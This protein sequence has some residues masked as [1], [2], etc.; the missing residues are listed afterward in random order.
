MKVFPAVKFMFI[1]QK[2]KIQ[3]NKLRD[4]LTLSNSYDGAF[5][6]K[7]LMTK[8]Y[9]RKK[10]PWQ[11]LGRVLNPPLRSIQYSNWSI[12]EWPHSKQEIKFSKSKKQIK[13]AA[14]ATGF[15]PTTACHFNFRYCDCF[16]SSLR[17]R[18]L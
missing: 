16:A 7:K 2:F 18:Q 8:D 13:E 3:N 1:F 5:S 11:T 17:F 12:K 14:T 10:S 9:F 6:P 4:A 15:E